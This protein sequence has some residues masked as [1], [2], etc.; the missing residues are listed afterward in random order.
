MKLAKV[1]GN[2]I[3]TQRAGMPGHQRLLIVRYLDVNLNPVDQTAV[4][5]DTVSAR[6]GDVVL[7]CSSSSAR[8]TAAT[9]HVC[10]DSAI[11]SI[12]E[13]VTENGNNIYH[14]DAP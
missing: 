14:R 2:V 3:A 10:T 4:C 1:I 13:L 9:Q 12:V 6:P 7:T 8:K 5:V 11:V